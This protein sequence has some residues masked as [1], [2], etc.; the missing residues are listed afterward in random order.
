MTGRRVAVV[1]MNL[2]G[3]DSPE[4]VRPF[5]RNLF[6]DPAIIAAPAPVRLTLAELISRGREKS[7]R[8]NYAKIGGASP[9]VRETRAQAEALEAELRR[10]SP[11][12][13]TRVFVAMRYWKPDTAETVRDVAAFAPDEIV[14]APLY[15]QYSTTTT[16]SSLKAWREAYRGPGRSRALCCWYANEGLVEAH[17]QAILRTWEEAGRPQVRLLFSAHGI[18]E[19]N[20]AAGDPYQWQV[21]QT[22]AAI[23][24][25]L[26]EGW[27]WRICYQSRV[28][29]LK[30]LQPYTLQALA[31]AGEDGVGVLID[32]VA[33]V[34]E[35]IETLVELD[36]DYA[37]KAAD[38]GVPLYLRAPASGVDGRFVA[39]LADAV[40][41]ALGGLGVTADGAR[42][43]AAFTQCGQK[44]GGAA[45]PA[46]AR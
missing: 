16:A 39:G 35:H 26:G 7:A 17:A 18:P 33:F 5:L 12:D 43:P 46:G 20:V 24:A 11:Q 22:C 45:A 37:E 15:P 41:R 34:S 32:P 3:P 42:C 4:A 23:A 29:P 28:G 14:L 30:W 31:E 40:A 25:R 1:L 44:T 10:R 27:D 19:R 13:E 9:L 8:E 6:A 21:E 2:G 38:L 36:I